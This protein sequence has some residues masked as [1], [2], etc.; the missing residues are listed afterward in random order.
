MPQRLSLC[1]I[2]VGFLVICTSGCQVPSLTRKMSSVRGSIQD[3][4]FDQGLDNL[5]RARNQLPFIHLAYRDFQVTGTDVL[6]GGAKF[7][8]TDAAAITKMFGVDAAGKRT[9]FVSYKAAPITDQNDIY[10]QFMAFAHTPGL[11]EVSP[12]PPPFPV[13]AIREYCGEYYWIPQEAAS[14]F[15]HLVMGTSMMRGAE[16]VPAAQERRIVT[17]SLITGDEEETIAKIVLDQ[18]VPGGDGTIVATLDDGRKVRFRVKLPAA[19]R[20]D[21]GAPTT[22]FQAQWDPSEEKFTVHN[23]VNAQVRFYSDLHP[24]EAPA[25][26][27]TQLQILDTLETIQAL[28]FSTERTVP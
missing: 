22:E 15:M 20:P 24:P 19:N 9:E 13:Y 28:Q 18:P 7:N 2:C 8:Y 12:E 25:A 23:L 14:A 21:D 17:A 10:E 26:D 27:Q 1:V 4:Y 11:L 16:T 6:G 5:I 3:L